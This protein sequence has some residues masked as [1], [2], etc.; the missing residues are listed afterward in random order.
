MTLLDG[1]NVKS[2]KTAM[3]ERDRKAEKKSS[4]PSFPSPVIETTIV[5]AMQWE[6]HIPLKKGKTNAIRKNM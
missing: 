2:H 3:E 1:C 4:F 6:N 5:V